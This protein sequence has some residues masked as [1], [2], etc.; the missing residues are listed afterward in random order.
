MRKSFFASLSWRAYILI[1][2][3]IIAL[4]LLGISLIIEIVAYVQGFSDAK[5]FAVSDHSTV[6]TAIAAL[7]TAITTVFAVVAAVVAGYY[8]KEQLDAAKGQLGA[9]NEQL[10]AAKEQLEAGQR[11]AHGDF[12]LRLDEAFLEYKDIGANLIY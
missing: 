8:A 6:S 4:L 5:F 11:I 1:L 9:A 7:I 10:K 2:V 3:A 12:L